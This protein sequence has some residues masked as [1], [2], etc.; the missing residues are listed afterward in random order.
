MNRKMVKAVAIIIIAAM[1]IT[2]FSFVL[3]APSFFGGNEAVAYGAEVETSDRELSV[4]MDYLER[5]INYLKLTYKDKVDYQIMIDGAFDGATDALGDKYTEYYKTEEDGADFI[6]TVSGEF[7]GIGVTLEKSDQGGEIVS[8]FLDGPA[9]RGGIKAGDVVVRIDGVSVAADSVEKISLKLR[10]PV[11]TKVSVTVKRGNQELNFTISRE[12][13][14]TTSI[15]SKMLEYEI[16]YLQ[17]T[18]FDKDTDSEFE[19]AL[20]QLIGQGATSVVID[21]RDNGGGLISSAVG[22]ANKLIREGVIFNFTKQGVIEETTSAAGVAN[23]HLPTV[24]LVNENS[25][26]ASE[27]LA[28]ALKENKVASLVGTTTYGK[29]IAQI[30]TN[31]G[32]GNQAKISSWY[33]TTPS[34]KVINGIGIGPDYFVENYTRQAATIIA[35]FETFAPMSELVKPGPSAVGLNVYGAQQRLALLGY[36]VAVSGTMDAKSVAAV[37]KF[38]ADKGLSPYGVLDYTTRDR[39]AQTAFNYVYGTGNGDKQLEKAVELLR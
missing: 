27:I 15:N 26:S 18:K 31:V 20:R 11:G 12:I 24:L 16:G 13:I 9:A 21:V 39:L 38:Q 17:I 22:V 33:F 4:Q 30:V 25:A 28:G 34:N 35:E 6:E 5:Y 1:V 37:R 10:G 3:I 23:Y 32:N 29:G 8:T 36:D 14:K 19:I 7:S 2:S